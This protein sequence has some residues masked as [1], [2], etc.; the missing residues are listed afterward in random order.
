M[1]VAHLASCAAA[2][3]PPRLQTGSQGGAVPVGLLP[4]FSQAHPSASQSQLPDGGPGQTFSRQTVAYGA[5]INSPHQQSRL[6]NMYS[7]A[8]SM[9]ASSYTPT[10][11]SHQSLTSML[12]GANIGTPPAVHGFV[13]PLADS[14]THAQPAQQA[15]LRQQGCGGWFAQPAPGKHVFGQGDSVAG[16]AL[17]SLKMGRSGSDRISP[18]STSESTAVAGVQRSAATAGSRP[19]APVSSSTPRSASQSQS[20][21]PGPH[22]GKNPASGYSG[23]PLTPAQTL[24]RYGGV[25]VLTE[26]EQS[27]VLNFHHVYYVGAGANKHHTRPNQRATQSYKLAMQ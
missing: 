3:S 5:P 11:G 1:A 16:R 24:V 27:E 18:R 6:V 17:P 15:Q 23:V 20:N 14:G 10:S 4:G 2:I 8:T 19:Q 22:L 7:N 21:R 25:S 26:Y 12:A 9:L 13:P